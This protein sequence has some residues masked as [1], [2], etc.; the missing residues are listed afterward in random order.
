MGLQVKSKRYV[1]SKYKA[2]SASSSENLTT[3]VGSYL[4][5]GYVPHGS[6]CVVNCSGILR[7][8]QAVIFETEHD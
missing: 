2:L 7:Y 8:V 1:V 4:D 3:Q 6:I 5:R